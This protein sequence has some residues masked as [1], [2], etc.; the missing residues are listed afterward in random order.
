MWSIGIVLLERHV[1]I[2]R[3]RLRLPNL[4]LNLPRYAVPVK[5]VMGL[6]GAALGR[7]ICSYL[8]MLPCKYTW[9]LAE[10]AYLCSVA[11]VRSNPLSLC[12]QGHQ[13]RHEKAPRHLD[14]YLPT[15][16]PRLLR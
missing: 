16:L 8:R 11:Y 4:I 13:H 15:Y 12:V 2:H 1:D 7:Y 10:A 5:A 14:T 3:Y 6:A 9:G